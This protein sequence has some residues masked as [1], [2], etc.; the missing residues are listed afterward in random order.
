MYCPN[1]GKEIDDRAVV[2]VHCGV[3]V[4]QIGTMNADT[5]GPIGCLLGGA[6]FLVPLLGYILYLV[7]NSTMPMKAKE[8]GKWALIGFIVLI[9]FYVIYVFI[10]IMVVIGSGG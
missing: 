10:L 2:C 4:K 9:V 6:C 1:C 3:A 5:D 7:W 8:A